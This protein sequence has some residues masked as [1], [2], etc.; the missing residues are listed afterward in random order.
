M[1]VV[2]AIP[3]AS[4]STA[5]AAKL[6][7]RR[8]PRHASRRSYQICSTNS[9]PSRPLPL[10]GLEPDT[11][12]MPGHRRNA[13]TALTAI[14][15][16]ETT[17]DLPVNQDYDLR[18]T[19]YDLEIDL[20][21]EPRVARGHDRGRGQPGTGGRVA[22]VE[23]GHGVGVHQVVHVHAHLRARPRDAQ[24]LR[25]PHV[26]VVPALGVQGPGLDQIDRHAS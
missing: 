16:P 12:L 10:R 26:D 24:D 14:S 23:P 13:E 17:Y 22:V 25:Q 4:V 5:T 3:T 21:V 18:P 2:P 6:L 8:S 9:C 1:V 11:S 20:H 7:A 15:A 19:S